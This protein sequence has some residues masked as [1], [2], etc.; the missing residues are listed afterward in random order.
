MIESGTEENA[1]LV[2]GCFG[3]T[4]NGFVLCNSVENRVL[5]LTDSLNDFPLIMNYLD[6]VRLFDRPML[7]QNAIINLVYNLQNK[8]DQKIR[9]LWT[10]HQYHLIERFIQMHKPCGIYSKL[11]LT[12]DEEKKPEEKFVSMKAQNNVRNISEASVIAI[13]KT[14]TRKYA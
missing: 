8:F 14:R 7:D 6:S 4:E 13:N 10:D 2:L 12:L 9:R 1:Y 3:R 5:K 11:I